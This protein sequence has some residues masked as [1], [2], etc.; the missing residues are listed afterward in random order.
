MITRDPF[1]R[2]ELRPALGEMFDVLSE[3]ENMIECE[4]GDE[5]FP[6]GDSD[7]ANMRRILC[8][9]TGRV[10]RIMFNLLMRSMRAEPP[11]SFEDLR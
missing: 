11:V 1:T 8:D 6:V 10:S 5:G 4:V 7:A 3:W 2:D 9:A